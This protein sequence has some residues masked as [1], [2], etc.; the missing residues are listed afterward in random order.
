MISTKLPNYLKT[1]R[2]RLGLFQRDVSAML[3]SDSGQTVCRHERSF[4]I[5]TLEDALAYE[6]IYN[7]PVSELFAGLFEEIEEV[8]FEHVKMLIKESAIEEPNSRSFQTRIV[9]EEIS[10]RLARG[11]NTNE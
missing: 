6:A 8:V 3:G 10:A 9:L 2:K 7:K 11:S 4:R 5:P 1:N